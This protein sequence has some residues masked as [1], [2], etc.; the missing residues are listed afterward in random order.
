VH[1]IFLGVILVEHFQ[2][3]CTKVHFEWFGKIP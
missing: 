3:H 1:C 2:T